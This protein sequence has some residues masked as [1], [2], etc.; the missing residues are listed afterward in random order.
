MGARKM[1]F[2]CYSLF[3]GRSRLSY[4]LYVSSTFK[5]LY[6]ARTFFGRADTT[7]SSTA[8]SLLGIA[9]PTIPTIP[10]LHPTTSHKPALDLAIIPPLVRCAR[11]CETTPTC[12]VSLGATNV[13]VTKPAEAS[14]VSC[15]LPRR[16]QPALTL[17]LYCARFRI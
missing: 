8:R 7:L 15:S 13:T 4:T 12:T 9:H 10:F 17:P 14:K 6:H 11:R 3:E 1:G 2:G 16:C 5:V